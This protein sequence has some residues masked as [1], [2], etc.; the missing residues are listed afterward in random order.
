MNKKKLYV[1][2]KTGERILMGDDSSF[3]RIQHANSEM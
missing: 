3:G 1:F 2:L